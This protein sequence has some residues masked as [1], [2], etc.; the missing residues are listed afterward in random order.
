MTGGFPS[1]RDSNVEMFPFDDVL[2]YINVTIEPLIICIIIMQCNRDIIV[3]LTTVDSSHAY[4]H[5][6]FG[7]MIYP[8]ISMYCNHAYRQQDNILGGGCSGQH[9]VLL[10]CMVV[11]H[12]DHREH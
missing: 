12:C 2:M 9:I 11:L 6:T 4:Q 8:M 7:V 5:D 1:Q 10:I 3:L